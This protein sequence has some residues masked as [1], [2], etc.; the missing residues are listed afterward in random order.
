MCFAILSLAACG[1]S[2]TQPTS[3]P[4]AATSA[5]Q[6]ATPQQA[7]PQQAAPT[8]APP[9][10]PTAPPAATPTIEPTAE[11]TQPAVLSG[12]K[13]DMNNPIFKAYFAIYNKFPR[14][15]RAEAFNPKTQQTTTVLIET[16]AKD[17][18]HLE[19]GGM[20]GTNAI[21]MSMVIIS[22]TL[23]L[24]QGAAWQKLGS[25]Q[26]GMFLGMLTDADSLQQLLNAFDE[27]ASYTVTPIGPE[28]V[29]GTPAMAYASEFTTKDGKTSKGKAWIGADGL[30]TQDRIETSDGMVITTTYEFDPNIKVEAPIP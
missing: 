1:G 9:P 5:P 6:Q 7:A 27:L 17:H 20:G 26:G 21:S 19:V 14:R 16:D 18:L 8:Q 10:S 23:Y 12:T 13:I 3:A 11:P 24:K 30:L 15:T 22:P 29:N 2:A 28:D 4:I 25:A